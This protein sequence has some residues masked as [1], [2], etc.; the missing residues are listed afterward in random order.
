MKEW[1]KEKGGVK[2]YG[3]IDEID[4]N[5]EDG[6]SNLYYTWN[7]NQM[8]NKK[9]FMLKLYIWSLTHHRFQLFECVLQFRVPNITFPHDF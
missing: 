7:P 3:V 2:K 1:G 5:I 4:Y 8:Q 6:I 9:S